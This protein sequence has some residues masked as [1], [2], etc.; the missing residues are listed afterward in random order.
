MN[1]QFDGFKSIEKGLKAGLLAG[2]GALIAYFTPV[3]IEPTT[4]AV[5]VGI[6]GQ[7]VQN[8][9]KHRW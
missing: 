1:K 4:G 2:I 8:Y 9:I 7:V 6:L 5:I 3:G